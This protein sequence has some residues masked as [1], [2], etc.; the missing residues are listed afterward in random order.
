MLPSDPMR[1]EGCLKKEVNKFF[2]ELCIEAIQSRKDFSYECNLRKDQ[3]SIVK[4]FEDNGYQINLIFILLGNIELSKQRVHIRINEGGHV[5]GEKSIIGNYWEGL[6]N[7]DESVS[8]GHWSH[9]YLVDNSKDVKTK[10]DTLTLQF[11]LDENNVIQVSDTFL[12]NY[13]QLLPGIW[14]RFLAEK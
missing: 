7:L 2:K 9:V 11:E 1:Y 3:L 10:G 12:T 5:V 14:Q 8:N 6:K 13:S 4:L